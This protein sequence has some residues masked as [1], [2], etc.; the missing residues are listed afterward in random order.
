MN[1]NPTVEGASPAERYR[2]PLG[3]LLWLPLGLAALFAVV[4]LAALVVVSWSSQDRLDPVQ[5]HLAHLDQIQGAG[6]MMEQALLQRLRDGRIGEGELEALRTRIDRI[7][8]MERHRHPDTRAH[9]EQIRRGLA[10]MH[11]ERLEPLMVILGQLRQVL[12]DELRWHD[13]LLAKTARN[14]QTELRLALILVVTIPLLGVVLLLAWRLH[15]KQPLND[16]DRLLGHLAARDAQPVEAHATRGAAGLLQPLFHSYNGLVQ[17][18]QA[19]EAEHRQ[20]EHTLEREVREATAALLEQNRELARAERLAAVGAVSAGLA[21]E[22][23][24]PLA[25]IQLACGK[26]RKAVEE[27]E[28][29]IRIDAVIAEL[30]RVNGLL[31]ETV[32]AARHAPEPPAPIALGPLLDEFLGLVRYQIPEGV[33]LSGSA[34]AELVCTIPAAGLRQALL[35]LVLNGVQAVGETGCVEVAARRE[36]GALVVEVSDD[37]PGFPEATL[38]VGVRPFATGRAGGTGLGLAMVRRFVRDHDGAL[39]LANREPRGARVTLRL[40]CG[41]I[42]EPEGV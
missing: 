18:L 40:P 36:E 19:L 39:E 31:N 30:R 41:E 22:L 42:E 25:G 29:R 28:Q 21:H 3:R 26:L 33:A 24:N 15:I 27:P 2:L 11:G 8:A 12:A 5:A 9:L 38:R 14:N 34:A 16:L 6:R 32:D 17:R 13:R 35:N 10:A 7:I 4:A 20:R 1:Q 37:G 23:R